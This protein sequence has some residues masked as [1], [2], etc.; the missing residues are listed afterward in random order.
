MAGYSQTPLLQKL[1]IKDGFKVA[2]VNPPPDY[3]KLLGK[4]PMGVEVVSSPKGPLDFIHFFTQDRGEYEKKLKN[5]KKALVPN[6][7]IWVSWPKAA[8]KVPTDV[9]E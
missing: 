2:V 3:F 8:S 4:L 7:M 6:G 5:L 1:G 9:T